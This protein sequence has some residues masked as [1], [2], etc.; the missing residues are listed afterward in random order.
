MLFGTIFGVLFSK[1]G[2]TLALDFKVIIKFAIWINIIHLI[3][4]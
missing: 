3:N 1:N 2:I 4:N